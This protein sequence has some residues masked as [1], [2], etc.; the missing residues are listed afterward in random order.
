MLRSLAAVTGII[1]AAALPVC[2]QG[3]DLPG[4][5]R[6]PGLDIQPSHLRAS[7]VAS[8]STIAPGGRFHVAVEVHI[9]D[10]W[11]F[12]SPAPGEIAKPARMEVQAEGLVV[13]EVLWPPDRL[14]ET[15]LGGGEKIVNHVYKKRAVIYVPLTVPPEARAGE[16]SIAVTV[17]GQICGQVCI[18]V[19]AP[20]WAAVTVG[21]QSVP[22]EAWS[23][24]LADGLK[25][26]IPAA[27][28]PSARRPREPAEPVPTV[29]P[30]GVAGLTI[31]AGL[32]LAFLAGLILNVMPCVLPVVPL[33]ILSLAQ[34]AGQQR[35][36][37]IT[38]GL[39]FAGGIVLFFVGLGVL[40]VF[41]R[42]AQQAFSISALFQFRPIRIGLAMVLVALSAN[43]FGAFNVVVPGRLAGLRQGAG[44]SGQG[45]LA[46]VGMG[47]MMAVLATPCSFAIL[48]KALAWAQIVPLWL[49]TAAIVVIG[50][51]MACPHAVLVAFPQ[52]LDKLPRPG[53]W[54]ELFKQSMGFLLLPVAIWLI[55][56]GSDDAYPGW[57]VAYGVVLTACLWIWGTWVRY[58]APLRRKI[59]LRGPAVALAVLAGYFML[60]PARPL[61]VRFEK[62]S[63]E[64]IAAAHKRGRVVLVKF[65][66]ATC[67]SCIYL[68]RTVYNDPAVAAEIIDRDITA[69]KADTTDAGTPASKML[70]ERF[71]G[72]PPLTVLLP[73]KG[74]TPV[75][76]DGKFTKNDLV[77][78][79]DKAVRR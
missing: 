6:I 51:G 56:A 12:Y 79:F 47:L 65:T 23:A 8:H 72:A 70:R 33:R 57:V 69:L 21:P 5:E 71:R 62:F 74:G 60:G 37:L 40:N 4:V 53:R 43:L 41:L 9:D 44:G 55:F 27:R 24:E 11:V 61:A 49:G 46:S 76:L 35:R 48:A 63:A 75:R 22:N 52:L 78:A 7:A 50:L 13:G 19:K 45:Y 18:D 34:M 1:L 58:D 20:A 30:S 15:D 38:L 64:T 39:A 17:S 29:P 3:L 68:D 31:W 10:G 16:R 77:E 26:A 2:A 25:K 28:L 36:R 54:M 32:G 73:P 14:Y 59:A 66:S 42:M 67:L